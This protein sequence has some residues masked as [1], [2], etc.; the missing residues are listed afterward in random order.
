MLFLQLD[1]VAKTYL[2]N[3]KKL[4]RVKRQRTCDIDSDTVSQAE[5]EIDLK[6]LLD[7]KENKLELATMLNT[8]DLIDLLKDNIKMFVNDGKQ[9]DDDEIEGA[10]DKL[11]LTKAVIDAFCQ[12]NVIEL[13][14][15]NLCERLG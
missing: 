12:S 14:K 11:H 8:N 3:K 2:D 4:R 10:T 5:D 7:N 13:V 6:K 1:T 15:Q 9:I